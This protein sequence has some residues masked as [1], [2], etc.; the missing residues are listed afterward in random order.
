MVTE[1]HMGNSGSTQRGQG[2]EIEGK[3]FE[4]IANLATFKQSYLDS[5]ELWHNYIAA[6][7]KAEFYNR[8]K[9]FLTSL[10][11]NKNILICS[12]AGAIKEMLN[13]LKHPIN[14][15]QYLEF[16]VD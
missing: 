7:S 10:P 16:V 9:E 12:H 1:G 5:N 15:I 13:I 3:S 11:K 14:E 4:E 6:E 8:L 2:N